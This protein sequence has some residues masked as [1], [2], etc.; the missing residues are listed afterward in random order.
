[1]LDRPTARGAGH[2]EAAAGD[3]ERF[4]EKVRDHEAAL[5]VAQLLGLLGAGDVTRPMAPGEGPPDAVRFVLTLPG[6]ATRGTTFTFL[7]T[8]EGRAVSAACAATDVARAWG[9]YDGPHFALRCRLVSS[10][11]R[12]PHE[13]NVAGAGSWAKFSFRGELHSVDAPARRAVLPRT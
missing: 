8:R 1:L 9:F 5:L 12:V 3:Y 10:A 13:L 2:A 6:K 4:L 11:D 7:A